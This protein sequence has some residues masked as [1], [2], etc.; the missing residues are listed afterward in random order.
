MLLTCKDGRR[1][2][3]ESVPDG[4]GSAKSERGLNEEGHSHTRS[5]SLRRR[6]TN[7][8]LKCVAYRGGDGLPE[9]VVRVFLHFPHSLP[10][11]PDSV[12]PT[13]NSS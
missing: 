3:R 12:C 5:L 1:R 7:L 2:V 9:I 8:G 4:V 11:D 10:P 6:S 13:P